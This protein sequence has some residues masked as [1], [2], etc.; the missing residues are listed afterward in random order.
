[1]TEP[2]Q[3]QIV[4]G[5]AVRDLDDWSW[6][7]AELGRTARR[8]RAHHGTLVAISGMA[9]GGDL[10]WA[11][12]CL[13]AGLALWAFVPFDEQTEVE[14][15]GLWTPQMKDRYRQLL[16]AAKVVNVIGRLADFPTHQRFE[17]MVRLYHKRN[18][19]MLHRAKAAVAVLPTGVVRGGTASCVR[20]LRARGMPYVH[21]DP[22]R[23]T[24][25][26]VRSAKAPATL[27]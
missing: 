25:D 7:R 13:E 12:A 11:Q 16:A 10:E 18:D 19:A 3:W 20:K 26:V 2:E 14:R 22:A 27:F 24:A 9:R 8:L 23:S 5:T 1:M 17:A 4:C 21:I 15:P 6:T